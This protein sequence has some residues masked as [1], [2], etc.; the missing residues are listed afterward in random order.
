MLV[1]AAALCSPAAADA[2]APT[3]A[4]A[5]TPTVTPVTPA[6]SGA[7]PVVLPT[8]DRVVVH[9]GASAG[10]AIE[11][12]AGASDAFATF[13]V[14]GDHYVVPS[15]A[16]PYLGHGLDLSL[17]DTTRLAP[18]P[19]TEGHHIPVV[20][21]YAAGVTPTAPA[22]VTFTSVSGQTATGYLTPDSGRAFAQALRD[23][24]KADLAAGRPA[25]TGALFGGLTSMAEAGASTPVQPHYPLHILQVNTLDDTGAAANMPIILVNTDDARAFAAETFSYQGV[26]KVAVPAGHYAA[27]A[28]TFAFDPQANTAKMD[29]VTSDGITVPDSGTVPAATVDARTATSPISFTTQKPATTQSL[30]VQ[31]IRKSATGIGVGLGVSGSGN[32]AAFVTP[33]PKPAVGS[34]A[35]SLGWVGAGPAS[36]ADSYRYNLE[37]VSDRID[38]N[39]SYTP[40][41]SSLA[42]LKHTVN[43]DPHYGTA[44]A[45]LGSGYVT[46]DGYQMAELPVPNGAVT[47]YVTGG[48]TWAS[49][50]ALPL[51]FDPNN[52]V[53]A[54]GILDD[55]ARKYDAGET[56]ARTWGH[57][58]MVPNFGQHRAGALDPMGCQACSGAGN[59]GVLL[60]MLGDGNKDTTG[61]D[62]SAAGTG[63]LYWNGQL[64]SSDTN[65]LG[66]LL[67][68]V[69]AGPA[70]LRMVLDFD[71]TAS[72]ITQS[73]KTHTDVTI[74]ISGKDD[75][76]MKLPAGTDCAAADVSGDPTAPCQVLPALTLNY[77]LNSL[78]NRNGSQSPVQNLVLHVGHMSYGDVGS[79]AGIDSAKVSV[80]FDDGATWQDVATHGG[81]GTYAAHWSNPAPGGHVELRVTA[82]DC[83]GGSITQTVTDPYTVG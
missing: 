19:S 77:Q 74:P 48:G 12:G 65:R 21:R 80:S 71:R 16:V 27:L 72:G 41:D 13:T 62:F 40:A 14:G 83:L 32:I 69:P 3:A 75:P 37:E 49:E 23:A 15:E 70:K 67:Q 8:G 61:L 55:D 4:D 36:D 44:Q 50:M 38:A 25:G 31:V 66:Y 53:F 30:D 6:G 63:Q 64:L 18:M 79:R 17:F 5:A 81:G 22:G 78:T 76:S 26:A 51:I 42:T 11:K 52:P 9:T 35:Y 20:L 54:F 29:L 39:Q 7:V 68:N 73:T 1:T 56:V 58:P 2:S 47:E 43:L 46:P 59:V 24:I 33:T 10:V 34:L 45:L 28:F 57:A 82:T 60:G